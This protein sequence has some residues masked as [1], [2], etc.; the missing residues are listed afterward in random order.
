MTWAWNLAP[1]RRRSARS[2]LAKVALATAMGGR[3]AR[4][5]ARRS[6]ASI[7]CDRSRS[8][9]SSCGDVGV[10]RLAVL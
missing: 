8:V 6:G 10:T 5:K 7:A 9:A 1:S 4:S 3:C 2:S